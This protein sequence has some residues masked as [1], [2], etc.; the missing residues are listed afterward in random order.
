MVNYARA[1]IFQNQGSFA[2]A[3]SPKKVCDPDISDTSNTLSA[4]SKILKE[5][6][7]LENFRA[8]VLK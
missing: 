4:C 6:S 5:V 1:P 7:R 8:N 3:L 2:H